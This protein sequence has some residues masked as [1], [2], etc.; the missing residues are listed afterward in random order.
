MTDSRQ[1]VFIEDMEK[2][3]YIALSIEF[4]D[5]SEEEP[6]DSEAALLSTGEIKQ[7]SFSRDSIASSPVLAE[8]DGP[9][10]TASLDRPSFPISSINNL[11]KQQLTEIEADTS[12]N[13]KRQSCVERQRKRH[14]VSIKLKDHVPD[15]TFH[16]GDSFKQLRG[17]K[18]VDQVSVRAKTVNIQPPLVDK[19]PGRERL[20]Q[21]I[22]R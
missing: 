17:L 18:G 11:I 15:K 1:F 8:D 21:E 13:W 22:Q 19:I 5:R 3:G 9:A 6:T 20:Q 16:F 10:A 7:S 14:Q 4:G 2:S 12:D